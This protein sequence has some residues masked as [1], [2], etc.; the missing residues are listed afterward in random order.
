MSLLRIKLVQVSLG[1]D[2][3]LLEFDLLQFLFFHYEFTL[4]FIKLLSHTLH[5]LVRVLLH[6]LLLSLQQLVDLKLAI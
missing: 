2:H 3:E 4:G 5:L 1:V 6:L